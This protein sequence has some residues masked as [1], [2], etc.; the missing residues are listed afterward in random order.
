VI[1]IQYGFET[2][3]LAYVAVG[4]V[5]GPL[6]AVAGALRLYRAGKT[7][8]TEPV[9]PGEADRRE[10]GS[11]VAVEG[12]A[13]PLDGTDSPDGALVVTTVREVDTGGTV[14]DTTDRVREVDAAPFA[15]AGDGGRVAVDPDRVALFGGSGPGRIEAGDSVHVVGRTWRDDDPPTGWPRTY[16][17]RGGPRARAGT[18]SVGDVARRGAAMGVAGVLAGVVVAV[19]S[20]YLFLVR[21]IPLV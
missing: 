3:L 21:P 4:L 14:A 9:G 17:G 18:G 13:E 2:P 16:V 8:T 10:P 6:V 7:G 19:V 1:P 11:L 20:L 5:A 15:V 12:R